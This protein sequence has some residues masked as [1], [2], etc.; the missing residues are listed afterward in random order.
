MYD[1]AGEEYTAGT[2]ADEDQFAQ[3]DT[4]VVVTANVGSINGVRKSCV[5]KEYRL[6]DTKGMDRF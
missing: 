4:L 1:I 3:R 5:D 2:E 6:M